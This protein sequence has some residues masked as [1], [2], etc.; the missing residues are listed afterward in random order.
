VFRTGND[1]QTG[2]RSNSRLWCG[3]HAV[4]AFSEHFAVDRA[5]AADGSVVANDGSAN[6]APSTV[7]WGRARRQPRL[8]RGARLVGMERPL[9]KVAAPAVAAKRDDPQIAIGALRRISVDDLEAGH[10]GIA[11]GGHDL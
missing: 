10:R 2:Q 5:L 9:L 4:D 7:A 1:R 3:T 11:L 8:Q 6:H